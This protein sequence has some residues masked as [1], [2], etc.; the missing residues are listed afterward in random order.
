MGHYTIVKTSNFN[1]IKQPSIAIMNES[2]EI[3]V[4]KKSN[5]FNFK[6]RLS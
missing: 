4:I 3:N 1:G 5:Y 2:Q 6:D